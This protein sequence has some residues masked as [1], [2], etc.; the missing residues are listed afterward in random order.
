MR[1]QEK[2]VGPKC[3]FEPGMSGP[4]TQSMAFTVLVGDRGVRRF[5]SDLGLTPPGWG[6]PP[7]GLHGSWGMGGLPR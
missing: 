2:S 5:G 7:L 3:G 6:L 1:D 4:W